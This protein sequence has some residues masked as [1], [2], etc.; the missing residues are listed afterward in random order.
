MK[1]P[2]PVITRE[3]GSWA[4]LFVPMIIGISVAGTVTINNLFLALSALGV[5]MSYVPV[6]T[7]L[8]EVSGLPQG[9]EKLSASIFWGPIYLS[10]GLISI[11]PLFVQGYAH[12]LTFAVFGAASFFGNYFLTLRGQKSILSDLTAV[13]GLT[14]SAPSAY[15]IASGSLDANAAILWLLTTL[16]FG[17]SVFYVHLK[18][19]VLALKKTH[20]PLVERLTLGRLN[21]VY[22]VIVIS[23]VAV[24]SLYDY[25]P[26]TAALAFLPMALH[27]IYGTLKLR[28]TV[29][30]K[31]LGFLLLGHSF[32]FCLLLVLLWS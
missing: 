6:H 17:C 23:I 9:K 16:F 26:R 8:R 13:A 18:I 7:I 28:S 3:H 12:L 15:Y 1:F 31:N 32:V 5:F 11:I 24:L 20:I 4:V 25:T 10:V 27:A 30:F 29:K 21:I 14:L 22:H 2:T 19:R